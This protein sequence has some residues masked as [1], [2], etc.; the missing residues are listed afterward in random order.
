MRFVQIHNYFDES[1]QQRINLEQ[2]IIKEASDTMRYALYKRCLVERQNQD[3][4]ASKPIKPSLIILQ[5]LRR[6]SERECTRLTKEADRH[7]QFQ[8]L[9]PRPSSAVRNMKRKLSRKRN[10]LNVTQRDEQQ[11]STPFRTTQQMSQLR[12]SRKSTESEMNSTFDK[13]IKYINLNKAM[14]ILNQELPLRKILPLNQ[15]CY[16]DVTLLKQDTCITHLNADYCAECSIQHT[17]DVIERRKQNL[18]KLIGQ[19]EKQQEQMKQDDKQKLVDQ[20]VKHHESKQQKKQNE[21]K[22]IKQEQENE[23]ELN[24]RKIEIEDNVFEII[25]NYENTKPN[26]D[27]ITSEDIQNLLIKLEAA[28]L[29]DNF[30]EYQKLNQQL[31]KIQKQNKSQNQEQT[32][33]Q[34]KVQDQNQQNEKV[35]EQPKRISK[36]KQERMNKK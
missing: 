29:E 10:T 23:S 5:R 19:V 8:S 17:K 30:E 7:Q 4:Y 13:I 2:R 36:F 35:E 16:L 11:K 9:P 27:V 25:E 24:G 33:E 3:M 34:N 15:V 12:I 1:P 18:I 26:N 20:Q 6:Q 21:N 14:R 22:K 32:S 28:F 31:E